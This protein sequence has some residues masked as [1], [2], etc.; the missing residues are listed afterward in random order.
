[1]SRR[2]FLRQRG[3]ILSKLMLSMHIRKVLRWNWLNFR[4]PRHFL[5]RA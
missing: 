2:Y 5:Y 1:L 4:K 3:S